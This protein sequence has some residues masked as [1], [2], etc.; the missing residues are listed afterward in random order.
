VTLPLFLAKADAKLY[1]CGSHYTLDV[2]SNPDMSDEDQLLEAE[3]MTRT[4]LESHFKGR[5]SFPTISAQRRTSKD[6]ESPFVQ[7]MVVFD[8]DTEIIDDPIWYNYDWHAQVDDLFED[9]WLVLYRLDK[10]KY[11]PKDRKYLDRRIRELSNRIW[12]A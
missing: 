1:T 11:T 9:D 8:G 10:V 4:L 7:I 6:D 5:A 2:G 3:K 12:Q